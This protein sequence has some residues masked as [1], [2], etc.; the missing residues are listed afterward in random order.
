[1]NN[2]ILPPRHLELKPGEPQLWAVELDR[3]NPQVEALTNCLS[4]EER[5]RAE[6]FVTATLSNH[7]VIAHALLR[8]ILAIYIKCQPQA[9]QF[10]TSPHGKPYLDPAHHSL[11]LEFNMSHTRGLALYAVALEPVGIDVEL[12]G[13]DMQFEEIAERF[14]TQAEHQALC[15]LPQASR[16]KAFYRC[17]TLKEAFVKALGQGLNY[18]LDKFEVDF[19]GDSS[20]CLQNIAGSTQEAH[21]WTL[22]N[23][24]Y[25]PEY[26]A[27]FASKGACLG[28]KLYA[29]NSLDFIR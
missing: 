8:H 14:F 25:S 13:R 28:L 6:R 15:A 16:Q 26:A 5:G 27:A 29:V 19:L 21:A 12:L 20:Q 18:G 11:A 24:D 10:L 17:W 23:I 2:W 1:M 3:F 7:Y 22:Q 4:Q 9:L